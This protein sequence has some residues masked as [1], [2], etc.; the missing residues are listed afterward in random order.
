MPSINVTITTPVGEFSGCPHEK[1]LE[2]EYV[3]EQLIDIQRKV[4]CGSPITLYNLSGNMTIIAGQTV[5]NSVIKMYV[6][7]DE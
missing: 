4:A 5:L 6:S 2:A 3:A 7:V 1:S